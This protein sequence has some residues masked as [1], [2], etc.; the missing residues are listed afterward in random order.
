MT[1]PVVF[2]RGSMELKC[3]IGASQAFHR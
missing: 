1:A 3:S 2:N